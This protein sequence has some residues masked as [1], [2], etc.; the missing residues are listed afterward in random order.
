MKS[1]LLAPDGAGHC[2]W[3]EGG[4][5]GRGAS[6]LEPD[7]VVLAVDAESASSQQRTAKETE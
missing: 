3:K 2:N 6:R 5:E 1:E 4:G 7:I